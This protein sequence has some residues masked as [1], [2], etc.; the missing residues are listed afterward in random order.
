MT[1]A[2]NNSVVLIYHPFCLEH[3]MPQGHP[4]RP[5][6][7]SATLR[8]LEENQLISHLQLVAPEEAPEEIIGEVHEGTYVESVQKTAKSGGGYLNPDT[9][10][11]PN[12]YRAAKLAAGAVVVGIDNLMIQGR[13]R[14]FCLVRP[15]GHHATAGLGMGFCLFN[16]LA[17]GARYAKRKYDI[18]KILIV[19]WDAH[20]GNGLQDIFYDSSDVLYVSLHQYP[21]YPGTGSI[22]EV[23]RREGEGYTVNIPLPAGSGDELFLQA[24]AKI[25]LPLAVEFEPQLIMVAAGYDGHF[26]DPLA[27]LNLTALGYA[28]MTEEI[29]SL[30]SMSGNKVIISLEGGYDLTALS[31]SVL[32]TINQLVGIKEEIADPFGGFT[33]SAGPSQASE[34]NK[35]LDA[36]AENLGRYWKF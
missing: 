10:I 36:I 25:I 27:S 24:F 15:P 11:S 6:R 30:A 4:E 19:D 34:V 31:Y 22:E 20:H 26:A 12:S 29:L 7:L 21:L 8:L 35:A 23:G 33:G 28:R 17:V 32:A 16:N 5:E 1:K 14:A 9:Y 2:Q 13:N 3:K 18:S